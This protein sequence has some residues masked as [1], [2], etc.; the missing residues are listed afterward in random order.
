MGIYFIRRRKKIQ[1]NKYIYIYIVWLV[2]I[3][4]CRL[5]T[6]KRSFLHIQIIV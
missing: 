4:N 1:T 5:Y 2:G 3:M 6:K